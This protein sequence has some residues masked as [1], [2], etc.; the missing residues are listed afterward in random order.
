MPDCCV[1][2]GNFLVMPSLSPHVGVRQTPSAVFLRTGPVVRVALPRE[3]PPDHHAGRFLLRTSWRNRPPPADKPLLL[4][5]RDMTIRPRTKWPRCA[6]RCKE[7]LRRSGYTHLIPFR[8]PALELSPPRENVL[9]LRHV[10]R[11][12]RKG[13]IA[14]ASFEISLEGAHACAFF[15]DGAAGWKAP[16]QESLG[17]AGPGDSSISPAPRLFR[18]HPLSGARPLQRNRSNRSSV[19]VA[20]VPSSRNRNSC[21]SRG[22]IPALMDIYPDSKSLWLVTVSSGFAVRALEQ[23][24]AGLDFPIPSCRGE[25]DPQ[26]RHLRVQGPRRRCN[27]LL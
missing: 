7:R 13:V 6:R 17:D 1:R 4:Q 22:E 19:L 23:Y 12:P 20:R 16:A 10:I 24:A 3:G 14:D 5:F 18:N 27:P 25:F 26:K 2:T 9:C 21:A 11:Y 8:P 15:R